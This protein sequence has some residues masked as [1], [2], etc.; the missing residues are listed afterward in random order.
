[1]KYDIILVYISRYSLLLESFFEMKYDIM[2]NLY[3]LIH[4]GNTDISLK[5]KTIL[6]DIFFDKKIFFL[7][8]NMN[9]KFSIKVS[10]FISGND[11]K[12]TSLSQNASCLE[13]LFLK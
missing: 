11:P 4:T 10:Y 12:K 3:F 2:S 7:L 6:R 13:A 1:M 9:A 5:K 8:T